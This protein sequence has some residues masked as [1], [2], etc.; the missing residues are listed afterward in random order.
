MEFCIKSSSDTHVEERTLCRD[1]FSP[2]DVMGKNEGLIPG[3]PA[4]EAQCRVPG[5][6]FEVAVR[7]ED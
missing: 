3:T 5:Q 6:D 4:I 1:Q 2:S 7:L